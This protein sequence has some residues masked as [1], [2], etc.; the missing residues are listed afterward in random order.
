[1]LE[2][3][4]LEGEELEELEE[5]E[6]EELEPEAPLPNSFS[7]HLH[8]LPISSPDINFYYSS[9]SSLSNKP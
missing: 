2:L 9:S 8:G 3:E 6:E 5:L 4:P 1:M 7:Q